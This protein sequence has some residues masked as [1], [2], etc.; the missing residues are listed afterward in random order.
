MIAGRPGSGPFRGTSLVPRS[1]SGA[2]V[3]DGVS[4]VIGHGEAVGGLGVGGG[5]PARRVSSALLRTA[6]RLRG[7]GPPPSQ[8]RSRLARACCS[9]I[10]SAHSSCSSS[11]HCRGTVPFL[12]HPPGQ[13]P[14]P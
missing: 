6:W 4:L 3:A 10:S 11:A 9:A 5:A 2:S 8:G 13:A 12:T 7:Y 1:G 14:P